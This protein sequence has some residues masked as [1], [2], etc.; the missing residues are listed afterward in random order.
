MISKAT[1]RRLLKVYEEAA[2]KAAKAR[3][4]A[5]RHIQPAHREVQA[6]RAAILARDY[7]G[8][9]SR[10]V[11]LGDPVGTGKTEVALAA[12]G[13]LLL[14]DGAGRLERVIVIAPNIT[15]AELWARRASQ[16]LSPDG[17]TV[18]EHWD[19]LQVPRRRPNER[20]VLVT[21]RRKTPSSIAGDPERRLVIVDEAHRGAESADLEDPD[22]FFGRLGNLSKQARVLLVTATPFQISARGFYKLLDVTE[23]SDLEP[24]KRFTTATRDLRKA[25]TKLTKVERADAAN[26]SVAELHPSLR[27]AVHKVAL[28]WPGYLEAVQPHRLP[29]SRQALGVPAAKFPQ[30]RVLPLGSWGVPYHVASVVPALLGPKTGAGDMFQRRLVSSSEAFFAGTAGRTLLQ[31]QTKP[32]KALN[33]ELRKRLGVG[34]AHPKVKATVKEAVDRWKQGQH[35]VVFCVFHDTQAALRDAIRRKL[36]KDQAAIV[37]P[38]HGIN[39]DV[40][41]RFR[42]PPKQGG[43][44]LILIL[45]D[46]LSESIDLDGGD[47]CLIHHDLPWNP[48][49]IVQRW[50]RLVRISSGF[51]TPPVVTPVLDCPVDRR[52]Y[53]TLRDRLAFA[54]DVAEGADREHPLLPDG[55]LPRSQ[56]DEGD[57]AHATLQRLLD[58]LG[59]HEPST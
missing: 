52:L 56:E 42:R 53:A 59:G 28:T 15:V 33:A 58:E 19:H 22:T 40:V 45:T 34:I 9:D 21:T 11:I 26:A 54:G 35:V 16:M 5:P 46:R 6:Q 1:T 32:M 51:K 50:G 49:R 23:K 24:V 12:A 48:A 31:R 14:M 20:M 8:Q 30:E 10:S 29:F 37:A 55:L 3:R 18:V 36:P 25:W 41:E 38:T 43:G 44:P 27:R 13:N 4:Q 17:V 7:L 39:K 57:D 47:P 2:A